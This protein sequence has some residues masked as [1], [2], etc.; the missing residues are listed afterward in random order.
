ML[1]AH[2]VALPACRLELIL[3]VPYIDKSLVPGV[4]APSPTLSCHVSEQSQINKQRIMLIIRLDSQWY[5]KGLFVI[6]LGI[7]TCVG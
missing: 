4:F 1:T 5:V 2:V 6:G 7:G 3:K